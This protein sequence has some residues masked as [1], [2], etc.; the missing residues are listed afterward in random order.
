VKKDEKSTIPFPQDMGAAPSEES[1]PLPRLNPELRRE[2][3]VL[4]VAVGPAALVVLDLAWN[5]SRRII[6]FISISADLNRVC[7]GVLFDWTTPRWGIVYQA[8]KLQLV[9]RMKI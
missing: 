3:L 4:D 5:E 9:L 7:D 1:L 2:C 6:G 8:L